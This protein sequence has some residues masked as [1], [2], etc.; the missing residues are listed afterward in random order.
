MI[1]AVVAFVAW[2]IPITQG[3]HFGC[4]VL[5]GD[6]FREVRLGIEMCRGENQS[7]RNAA[8]AAQRG[9]Q[10]SEERSRKAA[11]ERQARE[12]QA[13]KQREEQTIDDDRPAHELAVTNLLAEAVWLQ[14]RALHE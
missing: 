14:S 6:K 12:A 3:F 4:H 13:D 10:E 2:G 11:E 7:E 8:E 5:V 9:A 1:L